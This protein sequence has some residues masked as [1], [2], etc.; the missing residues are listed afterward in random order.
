MNFERL[1][2]CLL[3]LYLLYL[4]YRQHRTH[5]RHLWQRN[6]GRLPRP[7]NPQSPRD[8]TGCQTGITC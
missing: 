8:C 7:W 2:L 1:M 3:T 6:K 5:L 4:L